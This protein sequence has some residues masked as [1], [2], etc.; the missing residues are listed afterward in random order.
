MKQPE[1]ISGGSG[2]RREIALTF[3]TGRRAGRQR[4]LECLRSTAVT[5]P[6]SCAGWRSRSGPRTSQRLP[7]PDMASPATTW[8]PQRLDRADR[9]TAAG[10]DRTH[11]RRDRE[12]R[13]P[14]PDLVGPPYFKKPENVAEAKC[15]PGG[16]GVVL[17]SIEVSGLDSGLR[18]GDL[19][20]GDRTRGARRHRLPSRRGLLR[21]ARHRQPRADRY[22]GQAAGAGAVGTRAAAG[23]RLAA[24]ELKPS[25]SAGAGD[26]LRVKEV[27][28]AAQDPQS[29]ATRG[30]PPSPRI[31]FH[32]DSAPRS[33]S[34]SRCCWAPGRCRM[35]RTSRCC[36]H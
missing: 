27:R 28:S 29:A 34:T 32:C 14:A 12:G 33:I 10:G 26:I 25:R 11:R 17:R 23:H 31:T 35:E 3:T 19:R 8:D 2:E 13:R 4:S 16:E 9:G 36:G 5:P 1:I 18:G 20:A 7:R 30:G 22:G 15:R 24:A 21:R 6:S